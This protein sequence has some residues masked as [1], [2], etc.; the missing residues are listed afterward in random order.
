[1]KKISLTIP[2]FLTLYT[3]VIMEKGAITSAIAKAYDI[4]DSSVISPYASLSFAV[5]FERF[6]N[7]HEKELAKAVKK[8]GK[9]KKQEGID[10][11]KQV[12]DYCGKFEKIIG[13]KEVVI[14]SPR[15]AKD[16][17]F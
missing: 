14:S 12:E 17:E 16:R 9:F 10:I 8:L 13:S 4:Y 2:E 6:V 7:K 15:E 1:M 11:D 5:D 3:R